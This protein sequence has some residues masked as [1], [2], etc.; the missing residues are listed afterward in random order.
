M[1]LVST[2]EFLANPIGLP[3][4]DDLIQVLSGDPIG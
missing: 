4:A 2:Q 1:S 3:K